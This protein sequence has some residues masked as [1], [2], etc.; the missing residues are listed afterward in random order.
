MDEKMNKYIDK[1]V[2]FNCG[3]SS[4]TIFLLGPKST[5]RSRCATE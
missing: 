4:G 5:P 2:F 3:Y 1:T